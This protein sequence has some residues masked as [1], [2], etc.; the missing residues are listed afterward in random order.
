[1]T[2]YNLNVCDFVFR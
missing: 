1:M 2:A